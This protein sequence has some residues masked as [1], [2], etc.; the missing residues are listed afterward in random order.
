[1]TFRPILRHFPLA[2]VLL[3]S[4]CAGPRESASERAPLPPV[5]DADRA[6]AESF[7]VRGVTALELGDVEQALDLLTLAQLRHPGAAGIAYTLSEA[8]LANGDP[9][10]AGLYADEALALDP[11]NREYR[12]RAVDVRIRSNRLS[13]ALN[14]LHEGLRM[15]TDDREFLYLIAGLQTESGDPA[16]SNRTYDRILRLDGP[17]GGVYYRKFRNFMALDRPDSAIAQLEAV[18]RLDPSDTGVHQTLAQLYLRE[19]QPERA[20]ELYRDLYARYPGSPEIRVGMADLH[21]K[22]G[23]WADGERILVELM[24]DESVPSASKTE[25][26]QYLLGLY[27]RDKSNENLRGVTSRVIEEYSLKQATNADAQ[28]LAADFF[29][30]IEDFPRTISKLEATIRLAPENGNAWRQRMQLLYAGNRY[31]EVIAL[32]DSAE[33]HAPED[34]FIRFFIG[35]S[36]FIRGDYAS[37]VRWLEKSTQAPARPVFKSIAWGTMA[38]ARYAMDDWPAA[39][40]AYERSLELNPDNDTALN[41]YA[42]YLALRGERLE[43]AKRMSE[44]SLRL[45]GDNASYLDT[46]GWIHY[47]MGDYSTALTYIE[48]AVAQGEASAEVLEHKGDVLW[49]LNRKEEAVAWWRKALELDPSRTHLRAKISPGTP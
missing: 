23:R 25:V 43:E 18:R 31:D 14:L 30:L 8:Y 40:T 22:L 21:L 19:D 17:D 3:A 10:N 45:D 48:R 42:Y 1:M 36:Y 26:A 16:R 2:A 24:A 32:A 9:A 27:G 46:F 13:E 47:L 7:F 20:L 44:R 15:H 11:R 5:S 28:A 4:A 41:N 29:Y 12:L 49:K 35:G 33:Y 38:D 6:Q 37:A 39:R 34:A